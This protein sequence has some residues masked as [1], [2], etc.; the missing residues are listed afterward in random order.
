MINSNYQYLLLHCYIVR[1]NWA[2]AERCHSKFWWWWWWWWTGP[3]PEGPSARVGFW[4]R[5][6][7]TLPL[8]KL[9]SLGS[10]L[11]TAY[12]ITKILLSL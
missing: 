6:Q 1:R 8:H 11:L 2:P 12:R 9:G 3:R 7:R 10:A 5:R 4:G